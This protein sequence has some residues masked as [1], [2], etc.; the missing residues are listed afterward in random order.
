[1]GSIGNGNQGKGDPNRRKGAAGKRGGGDRGSTAARPT[2][3]RDWGGPQVRDPVPIISVNPE[4]DPPQP[5]A[6]VRPNRAE[7]DGEAAE[8]KSQEHKKY[9]KI[10]PEE[11]SAAAWKKPDKADERARK[12]TLK[13]RAANARETRVN[14]HTSHGSKT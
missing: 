7:Q 9:V 3:T 10:P 5:R 6:P 14:R 12:G 1:M 11:P 13:N 8:E 2:L 4:A